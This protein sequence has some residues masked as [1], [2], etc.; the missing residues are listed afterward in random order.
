MEHDSPI[1]PDD[2][3]MVDAMLNPSFSSFENA[4]GFSSRSPDDTTAT[5]TTTGPDS[6]SS[7]YS[8][9]LSMLS[10]ST[11]LNF[12]TSNDLVCPTDSDFSSDD[13]LAA[14]IWRIYAKAKASLPYQ[15]RMENLSWRMMA[16]S[17]KKKEK[18]AASSKSSTLDLSTNNIPSPVFSPRGSAST[19]ASTTTC[20]TTRTS[21]NAPTA[22][23]STNAPSFS[24]SQSPFSHRPSTTSINNNTASLRFSSSSPPVHSPSIVPS[25][26]SSS[27]TTG[28]AA[29]ASSA[30]TAIAAPAAPAGNS[31]A[32]P[33]SGPMSLA[34]S[35]L[36]SELGSAFIDELT[37]TPS[38][39][40]G[41]PSGLNTTSPSTDPQ[42]NAYHATS[43]AIPIST[44]TVLNP[45]SRKQHDISLD[46]DSIAD[47]FQMKDEFGFES[48][49][50]KSAIDDD[51][52]KKRPANFSPMIVT[53]DLH[54]DGHVP[55][56]SLDDRLADDHDSLSSSFNPSGN[57]FALVDPYV[58]GNRDDLSSSVPQSLG[59][60]PVTSPIAT[61][62]HAFPLY[63]NQSLASSVTSQSELY[64]PPPS[65]PHSAV[66]TPH[67]MNET[68]ESLFFDPITT[69][70]SLSAQS[71]SSNSR[72]PAPNRRSLSFAPPRQ[73]H[74]SARPSIS[75]S[76]S[77][78]AV[79]DAFPPPPP[80]QHTP[81]VASNNNFFGSSAGAQQSINMQH[82]D[83][84]QVLTGND[85]SMDDEDESLLHHPQSLPGR[86]SDFLNWR[87]NNDM[88]NSIISNN[89]PH[90]WLHGDSRNPDLSSPFDHTLAS[91]LPVSSSAQQFASGIPALADPWGPSPTSN[92]GSSLQS[93]QQGSSAHSSLVSSVHDNQNRVS[94][95]AF[96]RK[97]KIARTQSSTNTASLLQQ[98]LVR[99]I[100]SNPGTPPEQFSPN[101]T[102]SAAAST[103]GS[104]TTTAP[105]SAG[106][107]SATTSPNSLNASL[108][109]SGIA[110]G[111]AASSKI[112]GTGGPS[113]A[114]AGPGG[115]GGA[116][117]GSPGL[118]GD[119]KNIGGAGAG[120]NGNLQPNGQPTTCT[121]CHTQTTPLWRRDPDGHPLCN[122]CGLFLKLHGVVRPL[123]LK[124]DVIKKRNRSGASVTGT[125]G[126]T[127]GLS[128]SGSKKT[129]RKNSIISGS[130]SAAA[131]AV[132]ATASA[133][134][135]GGG[136][137][138]A[139]DA[140]A[141]PS[142]VGSQ[143]GFNNLSVS[144]TASTPP[145]TQ[146]QSPR[147]PRLSRQISSP[148]TIF[149][150]KQGDLG[151]QSQMPSQQLM[152][153]S[154]NSIA[155][156]AEHES[157]GSGKSTSNVSQGN[158]WEWLT[159]SL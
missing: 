84:S 21:T 47:G 97:Q 82:V 131:A 50:Y 102:G 144:S 16:M 61:G 148:R 68:R 112:A 153:N 55:D 117:V 67:P 76:F 2:L 24:S 137:T 36:A 89:S 63:G 90:E 66:S 54:M 132:A 20:A 31:P 56:Y 121:N 52:G 33:S 17:L 15:E 147:S 77:F 127:S 40:V 146:G 145:G 37:Y 10:R 80:G 115:N 60:S 72:D 12:K 22:F 1:I 104:G 108:G 34:D 136:L 8:A 28:Q 19:S 155:I 91:S 151:N 83:P 44:S 75:Q 43:N 4:D 134:L 87:G 96:G 156:K 9:R 59:F 14:R 124:T 7:S 74:H 58:S 107:V 45:S 53:S 99:R 125:G 129:V 142:S 92:Q 26:S 116:S 81:G 141:S 65:G 25:T 13:P 100:Q 86:S 23:S 70:T 73:G 35:P 110:V 88:G 79:H 71:S 93:Q 120:I 3:S 139:S 114:V 46:R 123:S 103:A 41:S 135:S 5:E 152:N 143:S 57:P 128:R 62:H 138:S 27:T 48:M 118:S 42:F 49:S 154:N 85:F 101:S 126:A 95:D 140:G 18:A 122:A 119:S 109:S 150:Q 133:G 30:L 149:P 64:S 69:S 38:S 78:S 98:N 159:M 11:M 39:I 157:D 94:Q 32:H 158:Q 130:S 51:R 113:N 29:S 105:T 106:G 111:G 6:L